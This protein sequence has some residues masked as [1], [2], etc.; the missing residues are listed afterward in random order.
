MRPR[1]SW[2]R[3]CA[4]RPTGRSGGARSASWSRS[5]QSR[6]W[7]VR[8]HMAARAEGVPQ[9]E[10]GGSGRPLTCV[11][12]GC[13]DFGGVGSAPAFFGRGLGEDEALALMD[14]AWERGLT[15]FDTADAYGGGRSAG[16]RR[17]GGGAELVLAAR[18]G[19]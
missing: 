15:H 16:R 1:T 6:Q 2:A 7:W 18:A 14:A 11:A 12:L 4:S 17:A 19:R 13:G 3:T 8:P 5:R 10:L 9:V